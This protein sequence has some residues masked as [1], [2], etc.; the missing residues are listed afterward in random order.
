MVNIGSEV[1]TSKR[2]VR[3]NEMDN[4]T[5]MGKSYLLK[6]DVKRP[7]NYAIYKDDLAKQ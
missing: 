4:K 3:V 2:R 1:S 6:T 5:G 7:I